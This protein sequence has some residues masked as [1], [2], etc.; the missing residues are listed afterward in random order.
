M[1]KQLEEEL[2]RYARWMQERVQDRWQE[3]TA[4]LVEAAAVEQARRDEHVVQMQRDLLTAWQG[5]QENARA[6]YS[7]HPCREAC[8][9]RK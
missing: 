5:L 6:E 1:K 8:S 7:M 9:S 3:A 2:R 4:E